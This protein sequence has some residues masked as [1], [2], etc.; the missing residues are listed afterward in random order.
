MKSLYIYPYGNLKRVKKNIV[1]FEFILSYILFCFFFLLK[2]KQR[3]MK[4]SQFLCKI[5]M[6]TQYLYM[7]L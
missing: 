7:F 6:C 4:C 5:P 1:H 3:N 2:V